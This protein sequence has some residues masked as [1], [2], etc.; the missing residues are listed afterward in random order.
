VKI[1]K[2]FYSIGSG[3]F[4]RPSATIK[5]LN[6]KTFRAEVVP[7]FEAKEEPEQFDVEAESADIEGFEGWTIVMIR[8]FVACMD[9]TRCQGHNFLFVTDE[10]ALFRGKPFQPALIFA[11][12]N[13]ELP[14]GVRLKGATLMVAPSY[15]QILD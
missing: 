15:T 4:F 10:E 7:K 14:S 13:G 12:K 9:V 11:S 1:R 5:R 2:K 6:F 3:Y 8:D